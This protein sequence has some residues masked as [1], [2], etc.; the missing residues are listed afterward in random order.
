[1]TRNDEIHNKI[2]AGNIVRKKVFLVS[3]K[4]QVTFFE[5]NKF[6]TD[7]TCALSYFSNLC[8]NLQTCENLITNTLLSKH[9]K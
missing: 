1:M 9:V 4:S 7:K 5:A 3:T 2:T 8:N 6:L